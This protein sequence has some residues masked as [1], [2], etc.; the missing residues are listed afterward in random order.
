MIAGGLLGYFEESE[1]KQFSSMLAD[2]FPDSEIAFDME[3]TLDWDDFGAWIEMLPPSRKEELRAIWAETLEGWWEKAPQSQR[4]ELI[5]TLKL[6][7]KSNERGWS[8]INAWWNK[9]S[10][11]EI[12]E[13]WRNFR[14]LSNWRVPKWA[15]EDAN[16]ITTW[17]DRITVLDQFPMYRNIPR[18]PSLSIEIRKFMDFS[19]ISARLNII[20]LRV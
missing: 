11:K 17:D 12:E 1:V 5:T 4:D 13:V 19:D 2:N 14:A 9:L 3:S 8:D 16:D 10:T 20:H 15:L 6:P 18:D 7:I